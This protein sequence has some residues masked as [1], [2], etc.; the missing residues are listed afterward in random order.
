[1]LRSGVR[2]EI[3]GWGEVVEEEKLDCLAILLDSRQINFL[4]CVGLVEQWDGSKTEV[5][6]TFQTGMLRSGVRGQ[7]QALSTFAGVNAR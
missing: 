2:D 1:M 3:L 5:P 7:N 6:V 4:A